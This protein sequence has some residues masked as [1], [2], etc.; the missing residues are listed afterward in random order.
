M[1][2]FRRPLDKM[3]VQ[4]HLK[5]LRR[6][7]LFSELSGSEIESILPHLSSSRYDAGQLIFSEGDPG[8]DLLIV[9]E[10]SVKV[11]KMAPSGRHQLLAIER[12]GSSLGEVSVFDGGAYST[13]AIAIESTLLLRLRGEQFRSLCLAHPE[14]AL[15]VIRMLGYRLRQ[16][17]R[18]VEDLSFAT[19]RDRLIAYLLR[20]ADERGVQAAAGVQVRLGENNEELAGR[21]GTVRE[22]V[23]RNL[24]RL[25]G[26]GL[27]VMSRRSVCIPNVA[28]LRA[29][30]SG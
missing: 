8:G 5:T 9:Q 11:V 2:R 13:T 21:L 19:V 4:T 3:P 16:L 20:L 24:G 6:V 1:E 25:H 28:L 15:K 14:V 7:P 22:L 10:G 12:A 23:S 27:I 18:L 17:R 29:E 26:Q 30:I